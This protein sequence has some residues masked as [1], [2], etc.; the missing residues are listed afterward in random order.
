[1]AMEI[2]YHHV[3][4]R[5][6]LNVLYIIV[7][8]IIIAFALNSVCLSQ[9]APIMPVSRV[10]SHVTYVKMGIDPHGIFPDGI[11]HWG[12]EQDA[13]IWL[14][15]TDQ[16]LARDNAR[17]PNSLV[18][19]Y[20]SILHQ[21]LTPRWR[22]PADGKLYYLQLGEGA[23][24]ATFSYVCQVYHVGQATVIAKGSAGEVD[25][26]IIPPP[27]TYSTTVKSI[28][29]A[30]KNEI[31]DTFEQYAKTH[32]VPTKD[33]DQLF[34]TVRHD[35]LTAVAQPLSKD[36]TRDRLNAIEFYNGGLRLDYDLKDDSLQEPIRKVNAIPENNI[37]IWTNGA[38]LLVRVN[39]ADPRDTTIYDAWAP[40]VQVAPPPSLV[41][42]GI[43]VLTRH[44]WMDDHGNL[45]PERAQAT[46]NKYYLYIPHQGWYSGSF[47]IKR[48]DENIAIA[49]W[50]MQIRHFILPT[51]VSTRYDS[52]IFN[53][54]SGDET[55]EKMITALQK[56]HEDFQHVIATWN[57]LPC[58]SGKVIEVYHSIDH[59]LRVEEK[60]W[61]IACS[62]LS[63]HTPKMNKTDLQGIIEQELAHSHLPT[64]T[65]YEQYAVVDLC[66]RQMGIAVDEAIYD[67]PDSPSDNKDSDND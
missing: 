19:Y 45:V 48:V 9:V 29:T 38:A 40:F 16:E 20:K 65:I 66:Q 51:A 67:A 54:F 50:L 47:S 22:P 53:Q 25:I 57:K 42:T 12:D 3:S 5:N 44:E 32:E 35:C 63:S 8:G 64:N 36:A 17:P 59:A 49:I 30:A 21:T 62:M 15:P 37:F 28:I 34:T 24:R 13:F 1:M 41:N 43:K 46:R 18:T 55:P 58:P 60:R 31:N 4:Q 26:M 33:L 56:Q 11:P 23:Y 27:F 10:P 7:I 6:P 52:N 61:N 2:Q 39:T 14:P